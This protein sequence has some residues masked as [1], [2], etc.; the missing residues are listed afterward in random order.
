[1]E[2]D[3]INYSNKRNY[4]WAIFLVIVGIVFLLNTTGVVGWAI[5]TYV[6]RFWP[7]L[8]VLIGIRIILG[9]SVFARI[10]GVILT[11]LLTTAAF[12][13]AYM[14]LTSKSFNFLPSKVNNWVLQGGG[15]MFNLGQEIVESTLSLSPT[16]YAV[17][18]ERSIVMDVGACKFNIAEE[19]S[20]TE[21]ITIDSKYPK[22][23][24]EPELIDSLESGVLNINFNGASSDTFL[25]FY[26]ESEY[27]IVLG[28]LSIPSSFDIKLGAGNGVIILEETPVKDFWAEVGAG[29]LDV[30]MGTDSIPSGEIRLV[31]GAGKMNLKIPNRVGYILEY[32][33]GVG[34]ITIGG[35]SVSGMSAGRGKYTSPNYSSTD[36]K[37]NMYVNVGVGS[38]NIDD[39]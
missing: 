35:S 28:Q 7:I 8:I 31:V 15:G 20:I 27:D 5:W 36:I 30:E 32:D 14:Q 3:S 11:I 6:V 2:G 12:G 23:N 24:K 38:F 26:D 1:M 37:L 33:L 19:E 16:E 13:I 4:S 10:I 34:E 25:L 17:V 39:F 22:S 29:K 18:S 21:Y 9:N